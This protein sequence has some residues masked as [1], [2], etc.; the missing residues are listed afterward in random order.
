MYEDGYPRR[1]DARTGHSLVP[2]GRGARGGALRRGHARR[3]ER[4]PRRAGGGGPG[5]LEW[6]WTVFGGSWRV[7]GIEALPQTN[8]RLTLRISIAKDFFTT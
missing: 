5:R 2:E 8:I 4:R 7:F 1:R 3:G 6:R